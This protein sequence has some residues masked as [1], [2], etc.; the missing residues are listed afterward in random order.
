MGSLLEDKDIEGYDIEWLQW[1]NPEAK[2][3]VFYCEGYEH[4]PVCVVSGNGRRILISCDGE[5]R[6]T[7]DDEIIIQDHWDL[8]EHGFKT[9]A[10]IPKL[11]EVGQVDWNCWLDAYDI[12][13]DYDPVAGQETYDHLDMISDNLDEIFD[14]VKAYL[15]EK[16]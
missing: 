13:S 3:D 6:I 8:I 10:D 16:A 15:K 14:Q 7:I 11:Y 2:S 1:F 5:L 4:S 12:T 9:D